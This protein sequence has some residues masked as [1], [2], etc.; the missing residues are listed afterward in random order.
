MGT[1]STSVALRGWRSRRSSAPSG[2]LAQFGIEAT[3]CRKE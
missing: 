2:G 3:E 1:A